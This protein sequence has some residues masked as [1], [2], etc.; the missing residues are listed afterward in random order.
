V[1]TPLMAL[2]SVRKEIVTTKLAPQLAD[3]LPGRLA[4]SF[5]SIRYQSDSITSGGWTADTTAD[6]RHP[7]ARTE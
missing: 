5:L 3:R 4:L 2:S 6:G 7:D 1:P